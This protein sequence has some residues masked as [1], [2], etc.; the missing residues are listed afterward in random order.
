M[1]IY[2]YTHL[3]VCILFFG[4]AVAVSDLVV[5]EAAVWYSVYKM[6]DMGFVP[7]NKSNFFTSKKVFSF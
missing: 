1:C 5:I 3:R 2:M 6:V 4:K 7:V